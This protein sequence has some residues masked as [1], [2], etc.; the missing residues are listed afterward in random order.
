MI[1]F[2]LIFGYGVPKG[3]SLTFFIWLSSLPSTFIEKI[4]LSPLNYLNTFVEID[5]IHC[6]YQ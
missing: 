1:R 4:T 3:S 6:M 2:E 5:Y